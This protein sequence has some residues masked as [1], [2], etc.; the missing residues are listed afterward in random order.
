MLAEV[1]TRAAGQRIGYMELML[2]PRLDVVMADTG[3]RRFGA[4]YHVTDGARAAGAGR[5]RLPARE[6][7]IFLRMDGGRRRVEGQRPHGAGAAVRGAGAWIPGAGGVPAQSASPRTARAGA[8][9]NR[10]DR[11]GHG[12]LETP[13]PS[14]SNEPSSIPSCGPLPRRR[15]SGSR[16]VHG[17]SMTAPAATRSP[18]GGCTCWRA[19]AW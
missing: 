14:R 1:T 2:S 8:R 10:P 5:A 17:Q 16:R 18:I 11:R 19:A 15:L 9:P 12:L 7:R 4:E 13:T 3:G 6:L